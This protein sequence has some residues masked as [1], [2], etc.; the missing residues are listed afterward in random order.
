MA[1]V[2]ADFLQRR[3]GVVF[4]FAETVDNIADEGYYVGESDERGGAGVEYGVGDGLLRAQAS[5]ERG[6]V[7]SRLQRRA[8]T[9]DFLRRQ[10]A[11]RHCQTPQL[12]GCVGQPFERKRLLGGDEGEHF[13]CFVQVVGNGAEVAGEAHLTCGGSAERR[14]TT[15]S[16]FLS[17]GVEAHFRFECVGINHCIQASIHNGSH[18]KDTAF[19]G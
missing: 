8:K 11:S 3:R 12:L 17:H 15:L 16:D 14:M 7:H 6:Y 9:V 1:D 13:G 18:R 10:H 2:V 4:D 19:G 5:E